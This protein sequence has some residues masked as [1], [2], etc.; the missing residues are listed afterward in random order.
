MEF[1]NEWKFVSERNLEKYEGEELTS[2]GKDKR[3]IIL[4]LV[5]GSNS[6]D[7]TKSLK[8]VKAAVAKRRDFSGIT[9]LTR[10]G[11]CFN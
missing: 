1:L 9:S 11:I 6:W 7:L 5:S 3:Q 4:L 2:K 8:K 10:W